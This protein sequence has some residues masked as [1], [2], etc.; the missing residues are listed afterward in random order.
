MAS[1]ADRLVE[2]FGAQ[3]GESLYNEGTACIL[4]VQ[5]ALSVLREDHSNLA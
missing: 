2:A 1:V 3:E 5:S 4:E